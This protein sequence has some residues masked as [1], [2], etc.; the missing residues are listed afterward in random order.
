MRTIRVGRSN[1]CD[2][3]LT[4]D[5]I[6]RVH[7]EITLNGGQYVYHD[8]SKN[9]SNIGGR[10]VIGEKIIVAPG[11]S[12][13][14]AN[15]V[16]LPWDKVYAILNPNRADINKSATVAGFGAAQSQQPQPQLQ[17]PVYYHN[18]YKEDKLGIGWG[19]LAFLIPL[20]GWIMYFCWKDETPKRANA[21]GIT[22]LVSFGIGLLSMLA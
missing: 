11:T 8:V 2:I 5:K 18:E 16:P 7:A 20:A 14:L 9:G 10:I 12:V 1:E 15:K 13:L 4:Y 17:Q 3:I 22:G 21:A 19:I 6:S